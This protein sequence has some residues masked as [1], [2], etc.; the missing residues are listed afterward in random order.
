[1]DKEEV[2]EYL[3]SILKEFAINQEQIFVISGEWG[4]TSC[5]LKSNG[6]KELLNVAKRYIFALRFADDFDAVSKMDANAIAQELEE[7]SNIKSLEKE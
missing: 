1:M 4:L 7:A 5:L 6:D 2:C 3:Q